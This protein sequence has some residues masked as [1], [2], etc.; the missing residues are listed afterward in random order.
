MEE[1]EDF[2]Y[3]RHYEEASCNFNTAFPLSDIYRGKG[4]VRLKLN[5]HTIMLQFE[6]SETVW[7][8]GILI[9]SI[10]M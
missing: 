4:R 7:K 2:C 8:K 9:L 1:L 3:A 6:H 5:K 10:Q